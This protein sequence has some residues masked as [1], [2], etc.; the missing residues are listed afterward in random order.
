MLQGY[1]Y[2]DGWWRKNNPQNWGD[3][4]IY[5]NRRFHLKTVWRFLTELLMARLFNFLLTSIPS[6]EKSKEHRQRYEVFSNIEQINYCR[7]PVTE[8]WYNAACFKSGSLNSF[9]RQ[10]W[11]SSVANLNRNCCSDHPRDD[12]SNF[13]TKYKIELENLFFQ[14]I[15]IPSL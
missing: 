13:I 5:S 7:V 12:F 4:K 8:V 2:W 10:Q 9:T 14:M 6:W 1:F 15:I 3:I 11:T